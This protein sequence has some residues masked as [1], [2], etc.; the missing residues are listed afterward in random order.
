MAT[1]ALKPDGPFQNENDTLVLRDFAPPRRL[2]VTI[3]QMRPCEGNVPTPRAGDA[4]CTGG[5]AKN[6]TG[7]GILQ[8]EMELVSPYG[9]YGD[10]FPAQKHVSNTT[11]WI[12]PSSRVEK[13]S[14]YEGCVWFGETFEFEVNSACAPDSLPIIHAR[15]L[16]FPA[17]MNEGSMPP[18]SGNPADQNLLGRCSFE[19]GRRVDGIAR[20]W[21]MDGQV[22][23]DE[24]SKSGRLQV[25]MAWGPVLIAQPT[26]HTP[27]RNDASRVP[28][29][30]APFR[31]S[32]YISLGESLERKGKN[33]MMSADVPSFGGATA[34]SIFKVAQ[35]A[36]AGDIILFKNKPVM[37]GI[38]RRITGSNWD[39]VAIVVPSLHSR[40][41]RELDTLE[42]LECTP[43]GVRTYPLANRLALYAGT[44]AI[45]MSVRKLDVKHATYG[46]QC[47][48]RLRRFASRVRGRPYFLS[49]RKLLRSNSKSVFRFCVPTCGGAQAEAD[50]PPLTNDSRYNY[51]TAEETLIPKNQT[52]GFFCSELVAAAFK[53]MLLLRAEPGDFWPGCFAEGGKVERYLVEWASLSQEFHVNLKLRG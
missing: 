9:S 33:M 32:R 51:N 11:T 20:W 41:G 48:E 44:H 25:A 26:A 37:S 14:P 53:D 21:D 29:S 17:N 38:Q 31:T 40:G 34:L 10:G 2:R 16:H 24:G 1:A 3:L 13:L 5:T 42:L 43:E 39:H 27:P 35:C 46:G 28:S 50:F 47:E 6:R 18:S 49:L 36:K 12:V 30:A 4:A 22:G 45:A 8:L 19:L 7:N 15:L 52:D 23:A